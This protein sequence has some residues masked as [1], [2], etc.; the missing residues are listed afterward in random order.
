MGLEGLEKDYCTYFNKIPRCLEVD[1]LSSDISIGFFVNASENNG[2]NDFI[3][4]IYE[5]NQRYSDPLLCVLID[6]VEV[7]ESAEEDEY[8]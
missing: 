7:N 4:S 2:I 3:E 8:F 1:Y 5:L 6:R